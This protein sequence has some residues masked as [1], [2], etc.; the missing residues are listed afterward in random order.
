[1][2]FTKSF[3]ASIGLAVLSATQVDAFWRLPCTRPVL[4]EVSHVG[5]KLTMLHAD[6]VIASR[7]HCQSRGSFRPSTHHHGWKCLRLFHG[8]QE[9]QVRHLHHLPG[10]AGPFQLLDSHLVLV[11]SSH[12]RLFIIC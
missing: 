11:R 5:E 1:M 6:I 4:V 2:M 3:I 10:S 12:I 7:S 9:G 8:F